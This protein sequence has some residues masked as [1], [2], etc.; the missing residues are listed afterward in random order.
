MNPFDLLDRDAHQLKIHLINALKI[1]C[2]SALAIFIAMGFG[3]PGSASAGTI[4]LL[5][6][7]AQTRKDTVLLILRRLVSY[8]FTVLIC[9]I[10]FQTVADTYIAYAFFLV[11]IVFLL[12]MLGWQSTLSVN[13]VIG[14][15]FLVNQ[16]FTFEFASYQLALLLIG[17]SIALIFNLLQ[18]D[19]TEKENLKLRLEKIECE[20]KEVVSEVAQSLLQKEKIHERREYLPKL[21]SDLLKSIEEASRF[22]KNSFKSEDKWFLPYFEMRLEQCLILEELYEHTRSISLNPQGTHA[23]VDYMDSLIEFISV[24]DEPGNKLTECLEL[25]KDILAGKYR[26]ES[27]ESEAMLLFVIFDVEKFVEL[28]I[29]FVTKLSKEQMDSYKKLKEIC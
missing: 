21:H 17:I 12:E 18:P 25:K 26:M 22:Q 24:H 11:I 5:T 23:I 4:T 28:K 6:L 1:G 10:V 16:E 29:E 7:I 14:A 3:L 8:V 2:G 9:W 27:F 19:L 13:A 20:M 15:Q